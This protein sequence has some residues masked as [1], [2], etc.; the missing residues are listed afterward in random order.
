MGSRLKSKPSWLEIFPIDSD[1]TYNNE[2]GFDKNGMWIYGNASGTA[3]PIRTSFSIN[4]NDVCEI[5][6]TI[7]H[8]DSCS[9]HSVAIFNADN[10]PQWNW[11]FNNSRIAV[12]TNCPDPYIY[13]QSRKVQ[14]NIQIDQP[15]FYT[16]V[17]TYEPSIPLVTTK[18][19]AGKQAIG[20]PLDTIVLSERLPEGPYKVGFDAD[21][22]EY[23]GPKAYFT[24]LKITANGNDL[25]PDPDEN[26][27]WP[28]IEF[29]IQTYNEKTLLDLQPYP[30]SLEHIILNLQNRSVLID[31][32]NYKHGDKLTFY[33]A[34]AFRIKQLYVDSPNP[35]MKINSISGDVPTPDSGYL[36]V[37]GQNNFGKLGTNDTNNYSSPVQTVCNTNS[38][39]KV[40]TGYN[41]TGSIK[42]D[43]TL[44]M[45][46]RNSYGELGTNDTNDCSSP[47]QTITAGTTWSQLS[48]GVGHTAA[49]KNDGTLWM[50]GLNY[51]GQ[52]GTE[53]QTNRSS[54]IQTASGGSNWVQVSSGYL[55][56][57]AVKNDGTLWLWGEGS[58][59]QLGN[60]D[61]SRR[62]SPNQ[63]GGDTNWS[64]IACGTFHS[65]AVKTDGSLWL[66]G[67]NGSGQLGTGDN[68][69]FSSPIQTICGGNNWSQV[70]CGYSHTAA[71]K[72]DGTLWT[73]GN[74]YA[75]R[76]GDGTT[77]SRNSP[78]QEATFGTTWKE[79][80]CDTYGTI[81]LK[82]DKTLWTWGYN[83]NG[84]LGNGKSG[85]TNS[86]SFPCQTMTGGKKWLDFDI[87]G[88]GAFGISF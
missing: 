17:I 42:S 4:T 45:W 2:F 55:F 88:E 25:T 52:L 26:F 53:D 73:W 75:G 67:N 63:V 65:A 35:V 85:W 30:D 29:E 12:S 38:W 69:N 68:T 3:Y 11:G 23:D 6:Y 20:D 43:G 61:T 8:T 27:I 40:S 83:E 36:F 33:G 58:N 51:Q 47:V 56:T 24:Y 72:T 54:P 82:W 50:W 87:G 48:C 49:I 21:L 13:G 22:D 71:V 1:K 34:E 76:L 44:W 18:I 66:W 77:D 74:N 16:F 79:V 57:G 32:K 59:G 46:G 28:K 37:W 60:D 64:Q 9:D 80:K 7:N 86:R 62:S 70:S 39:K 31:H 5:T 81:A 14:A 78:V 41:H 15:R 84:Q 19:Y 10:N